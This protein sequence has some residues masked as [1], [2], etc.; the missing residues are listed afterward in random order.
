MANVVNNRRK[1][2]VFYV[3]E[4]KEEAEYENVYDIDNQIS[5]SGIFP[6]MVTDLTI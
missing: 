3:K 2:N 1:C 5:V 4:E 6:E